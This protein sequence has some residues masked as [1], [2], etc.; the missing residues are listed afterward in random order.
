MGVFGLHVGKKMI[1]IGK[2]IQEK[3]EEKNQ[4]VVWLSQQIP[5]SRA[6]IYKIFSKHSIDTE[7][8]YRISQIL[9][10]DFFQYYSKGL[11]K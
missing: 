6:N 4:T 1:P 2:L 10:F 8:L 9:E 7:M 5:C 3:L 11:D